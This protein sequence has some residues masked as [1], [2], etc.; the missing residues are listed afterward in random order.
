MQWTD[1]LNNL[2]KPGDGRPP[3]NPKVN[4][5]RQPSFEESCQVEKFGQVYSEAIRGRFH[6]LRG[7]NS[8]REIRRNLGYNAR[9]ILKEQFYISGI[10]RFLFPGTIYAVLNAPTST[11][12]KAEQKEVVC[13]WYATWTKIFG[14][15]PAA[16]WMT[17]EFRLRILGLLDHKMVE[18]FYKLAAENLKHFEA[19]QPEN[20]N[21]EMENTM[22]RKVHPERNEM[23]ATLQGHLGAKFVTV[24]VAAT[25]ANERPVFLTYK[26]IDLDLKE[27]DGVIVQFR[28]TLALGRVNMVYDEVP[29]SDEYDYTNALR[30][31]VQKIDVARSAQLTALDKQMLQKITASEASDRFERLQR[32]LGAV[33]D[34]MTLTLPELPKE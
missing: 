4:R 2:Y 7:W 23:I 24:T 1:E 22:E 17:H 11:I 18:G 8:W 33:I 26:A 16:E 12:G 3:T 10:A 30:H 9:V 27:G 28:D 32:Q 34:T 20:V 29:T 15:A 14:Q 31:V 6:H 19:D 25:A 13:L 5:L 21:M